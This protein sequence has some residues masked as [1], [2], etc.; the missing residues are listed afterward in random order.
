MK[1]CIISVALV[2]TKWSN[3]RDGLTKYQK[4]VKKAKKSGSG[5][6]PFKKYLFYDFLQFLSPATGQ[7][8]MDD[9][10]K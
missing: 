8:D 7:N 5:Q 10:S 2:K 9:A 4:K 6:V 3:I 1:F